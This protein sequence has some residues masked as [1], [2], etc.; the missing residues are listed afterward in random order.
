MT[1]DETI[2]GLK[3]HGDY[4]GSCRGCPYED[5][6]SGQCTSAL[7]SDAWYYLTSGHGEPIDTT[8]LLRTAE[9][10]ATQTLRD[11]TETL[12]CL[13]AAVAEAQNKRGTK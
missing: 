7:C 3:K 8:E 11:L 5:L 1:R 13:H 10:M 6:G 9:D 4:N 2:K 12:N